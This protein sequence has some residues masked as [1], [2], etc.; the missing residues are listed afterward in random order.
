M[1]K[2]IKVSDILA[3]AIGI[4]IVLPEFVDQ[5]NSI[6]ERLAV[7]AALMIGLLLSWHFTR[8]I[9]WILKSILFAGI[10]LLSALIAQLAIRAFMP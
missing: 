2:Q 1:K 5:R 4:L 3:G 7:A 6:E 9:H 8:G 10:C